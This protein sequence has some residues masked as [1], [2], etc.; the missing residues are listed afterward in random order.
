MPSLGNCHEPNAASARN[1]Q[2]TWASLAEL[3][4]AD[5]DFLGE[6]TNVIADENRFNKGPGTP[7]T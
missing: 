3:P 2:P 5:P 1:V 4:L 7:T 6:R